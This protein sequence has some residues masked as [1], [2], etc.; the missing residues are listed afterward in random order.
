MH[1]NKSILI[2]AFW[3]GVMATDLSVGNNYRRPFEDSVSIPVENKSISFESVLAPRVRRNTMEAENLE[4]LINRFVGQLKSYIHT[5]F[6]DSH[7]FGSQIDILSSDLSEIARQVKELY[8]K[9]QELSAQLQFAEH[10]F[11]TMEYSADQMELFNQMGRPDQALINKM[12]E[13]NVLVFK[14][15]NTHGVLDY[16]VHEPAVKVLQLWRQVRSLEAKFGLLNKVP[17]LS[18][19]CFERQLAQAKDAIIRLWAQVS[20]NEEIPVHGNANCF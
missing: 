18:R 6:F 9:E 1:F 2:S 5:T 10:M 17:L 7:L 20:K 19:R 16:S 15:Y 3:C 8:P 11:Q 4:K 12:F 14:L 13:F